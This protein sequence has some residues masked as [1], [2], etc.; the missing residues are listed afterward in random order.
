M[1]EFSSDWLALRETADARARSARLCQAIVSGLA[2]SPHVKAVDL[3]AGTGSN[4]RYLASRL[5]GDQRWLLVDADCDLVGQVA[6]RMTSW[7]GA[8]GYSVNQEHG[9][10]VVRQ[11][12]WSCS[13]ETRCARLAPDVL[14]EVIVP[15]SLVSASALLDLVSDEWIGQLARRCRDASATVLLA[16]TY[17][18]HVSCAPH[19]ADDDTVI[20]LVNRH[21]RID[22]GF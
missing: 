7:A 16:L 4:V 5:R 10:L 21:Q 12:A 11:P 6:R 17:N 18:G 8:H 22:K 13:V 3:A 20:A 14:S 15:G 2:R 19:D 9:H 1:G